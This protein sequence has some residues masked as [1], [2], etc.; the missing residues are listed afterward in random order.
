MFYSLWKVETHLPPNFGLS[1]HVTHL[2]Q[3]S[4]LQ[5]SHSPQ[6]RVFAAVLRAPYTYLYQIILIELIND[7]N[8]ILSHKN[9]EKV[10]FMKKFYFL[11]T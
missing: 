5:P 6:R 4:L 1:R 7:R 3:S 10:L 2:P 9:F 8:G 11:L